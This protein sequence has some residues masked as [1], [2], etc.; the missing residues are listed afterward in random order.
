MIL[1]YY[2]FDKPVDDCNKERNFRCLRFKRLLLSSEF[3]SYI[4]HSRLVSE[5]GNKPVKPVKYQRGG[6]GGGLPGG[7]G[8]GLKPGEGETAPLL[9]LTGGASVIRPETGTR[10]PLAYIH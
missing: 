10:W 6:G 7:G 9:P 1:S 3:F 8:G 2:L 4:A 5:K